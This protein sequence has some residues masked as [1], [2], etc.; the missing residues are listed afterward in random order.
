MIL[1]NR[2]FPLQLLSMWS[3]SEFYRLHNGVAYEQANGEHLLLPQGV[4][5]R[6]EIKGNSSYGKCFVVEV[7]V[8]TR[9]SV[10]PLISKYRQAGWKYEAQPSFFN[11]LVSI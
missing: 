6:N 5:I 1:N 4:W 10:L 3:P 7:I 2:V 11:Q 8:P 9:V